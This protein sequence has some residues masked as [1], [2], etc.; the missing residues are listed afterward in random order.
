MKF[1]FKAKKFGERVPK[2]FNKDK[3]EILGG[4]EETW[5]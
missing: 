5:V 1:L 4:I 3:K 2:F